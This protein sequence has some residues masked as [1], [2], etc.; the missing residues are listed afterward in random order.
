MT[1]YKFVVFTNPVEGRDADY[2]R[3]YDDVHLGEVTS[4]P[5]F[6]GAKRFRLLPQGDSPP[7]HRY[8][9]IYEIESDD[10]QATM[11]GLFA[12]ASAGKL[13]MSDAL[14]PD[15]ETLLYEEIAAMEAVQ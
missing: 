11:G 15:V 8:M 3:W 9:A 6:T 12:Q 14:A 4:L 1:A 2:N 7:K 13:N 5:G 10:V